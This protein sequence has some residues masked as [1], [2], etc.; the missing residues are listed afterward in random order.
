MVT[1]RRGLGL[2]SKK[3]GVVGRSRTALRTTSVAPGADAGEVGLGTPLTLG[4]EHFGPHHNFFL[5]RF[6]Q[7]II[8]LIFCFS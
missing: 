5:P 7:H 3:S 1:F 2:V 6:A 8:S 4:F